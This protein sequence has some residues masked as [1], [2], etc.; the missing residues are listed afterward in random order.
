MGITKM[1]TNSSELPIVKQSIGQGQLLKHYGM[2]VFVIFSIL[3]RW[4][5]KRDVNLKLFVIA[6]RF[7]RV[8][9]SGLLIKIIEI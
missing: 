3:R 9:A 1:R 2:K 4:R 5:M 8:L 7:L 6:Q